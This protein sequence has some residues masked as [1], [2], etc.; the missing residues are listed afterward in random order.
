M[1]V[2]VVGSG[3]REHAL[4]WKLK[5][6]PGLEALYCAP[7]NAG[8]AEEAELVPIRS[9]DLEGLQSFAQEHAIDLTVVGPE[10][11]LVLGIVDLFSA[12]GLT[13]FGPTRAAARLEGSKVFSKEFMVRQKIPTA[14][15]ASFEGQDSAPAERFLEQMSFPVV[16]KADGLAAGKGVLICETQREAVGAIRQ[17]MHSGA[18]GDAGKKIVI[19]EFLQGEEVSVFAIS[20]GE[21][22]ALL[23]AAQ[24]HKR[25]FDGDKGK[26]TGG[27]GAY[28]PAPIFTSELKRRVERDI[29]T[30]T[31]DGM[32]SEGMPYR[33]C[34]YAGLMVTRDG[35][36]VLEYNCRFGDPEAQVVLPLVD[37][38]L[39]RIL[40]AA[41]RGCL[42]PASVGLHE[43]S[44]V[45]VVMASRGYPDAVDAGK[46]IRGLDSV[47]AEQGE[48]VFH[49][50]TRRE[51]SRIVSA[52]G[53]VLAVTAIGYSH[54]LASTIADAY[55]IVHR[56]AFD[57]AYYR[58]D[59]GKRALKAAPPLPRESMPKEGA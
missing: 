17:M 20:D 18:F 36:K 34:L 53:R 52:G 24:D 50:G 41:A 4:A 37:A 29:I 57:G 33:G 22:F 49:A 26:N 21:R 35:P 39:A 12:H 6:S 31:L 2:L 25:I 23:P 8:I 51:G 28:A 9:D 11:P 48:V 10:Q 38:D 7:G 55:R 46:A 14:R 45:T 43:A 58:S 27:M 40:E 56:I 54:E 44:A 42:E 13:I 3:G 19:E 30:P 47:N 32:R 15:F 16:V 1:K 59:I 5:Q